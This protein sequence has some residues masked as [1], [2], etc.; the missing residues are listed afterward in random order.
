MNVINKRGQPF[1]TTGLNNSCVTLPSVNASNARPGCLHIKTMCSLSHWYEKMN[2]MRKD[3]ILV[4]SLRVQ[5]MVWVMAWQ[6]EY[7]VPGYTCGQEPETTVSTV[8]LLSSLY[9]FCAFSPRNGVPHLHPS[10]KPVWEHL[11]RHSQRCVS[12]GTPNPV[13]LRVI[14]RRFHGCPHYDD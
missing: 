4:Y 1:L 13:R 5:F 9:S 6:L 7:E 14:T 12:Q 8:H 2:L 11:H 3:F 10:V